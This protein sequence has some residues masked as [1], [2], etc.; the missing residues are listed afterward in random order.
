MNAKAPT[1][2]TTTSGTLSL[3]FPLLL[4]GSVQQCMQCC[5][6][7]HLLTKPC[8]RICCTL[9]TDSSDTLLVSI[10][11]VRAGDVRTFQQEMDSNMHTFCV[12]VHNLYIGHLTPSSRSLSAETHC[13]VKSMFAADLTD[14]QRLC[15]LTLPHIRIVLS[16][17][18][19]AQHLWSSSLQWRLSL[20]A[21]SASS[22]HLDMSAL[23]SS[24]VLFVLCCRAHSFCWRN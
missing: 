21:V 5:M 4:V 15:C 12:Q 22:C 10:Q 8:L 11:A 14:T 2:Y 9:G 1:R 20:A 24:S 6:H 3:H 23:T 16:C 17:C 7:T 19:S 13:I 18:F